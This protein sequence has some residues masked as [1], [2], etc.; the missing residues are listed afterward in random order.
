MK[1]KG[2]WRDRWNTVTDD[3]IISA[4]K[5]GYSI[6]WT[7]ERFSVSYECVRRVLI[8]NGVE[9]RAAC[10]PKNARYCGLR[11]ESIR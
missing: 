8:R 11:E 3:R 5:D 6:K 1:P 2:V 10:R 9:R 4:Y 7:A